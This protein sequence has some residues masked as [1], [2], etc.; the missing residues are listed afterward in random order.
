MND[1]ELHIKILIQILKDRD[2]ETTI[3]NQSGI[4]TTQEGINYKISI[5]SNDH[6]NFFLDSSTYNKLCKSKEAFYIV[7]QSNIAYVFN[8]KEKYPSQQEFANQRTDKYLKK[9]HKFVKVFDKY[10]NIAIIENVKTQFESDL[11]RY[12]K[13]E[14]TKNYLFQ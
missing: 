8:A 9:T 3:Y 2:I 7:I 13:P 12:I 6:P 11:Q 1:T 5:R 10:R 4:L 14:P